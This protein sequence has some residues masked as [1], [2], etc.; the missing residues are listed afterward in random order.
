MA[1][2][3]RRWGLIRTVL[4]VLGF[5]SP[6]VLIM[7]LLSYLGVDLSWWKTP[8]TERAEKLVQTVERIVHSPETIDP[9]P[10]RHPPEEPINRV[11]RVPEE[12]PPSG[13]A[14]AA[15]K[16]KDD[17]DVRKIADRR[18][19]HSRRHDERPP[20]R[21]ERPPRQDEK[22]AWDPP[23]FTPPTIRR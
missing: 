19:E 11:I 6:A 16:D 8:E 9:P 12:L 15:R 10:A 21:D 17:K 14:I 3:R 23:E 20:R 18:E 13:P 5:S 1:R 22:P 2:T 4:K 7:G